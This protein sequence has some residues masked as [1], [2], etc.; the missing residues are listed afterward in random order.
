MFTL[1]QPVSPKNHEAGKSPDGKCEN[2]IGWE[3]SSGESDYVPRKR[4]GKV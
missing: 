3:K 1:L 2:S 4:R